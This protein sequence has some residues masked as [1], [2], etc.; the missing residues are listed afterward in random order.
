M[1][2]KYSIKILSKSVIL[3]L[4]S[5]ILLSASA[6]E[7][8]Q[9]DTKKVKTTQETM[10]NIILVTARKKQGAEPVTDTPLSITA[11]DEKLLDAMYVQDLADMSYAAPNVQFDEVGTFPGVQ[12]FTFRGQ[13]INSSIPSVDPTVGMF[14]DG[15]FMGISYGVVNDMFD[16]ESI[17]V[18]RGPQGLLF[19]RNVTGGAVSI[20]TKRP[21]GEFGGKLKIQ[22]TDH[23]ETTIA[24]AI[25]GSLI[26]DKL[27]AKLVFYRNDDK[28]YFDYIGTGHQPTINS[29]PA[30]IA[31][32]IPATYFT[33]TNKTEGAYETTFVRAS[34][35][36]NATDDLEFTLIAED[37]SNDGDGAAWQPTG[38][39]FNARNGEY[40]DNPTGEYQTTADAPGFSKGEWSHLIFETN[41]KTNSGVLTNLT[42]WRDQEFS[43]DAD[44]DGSFLTIF[45]AHGTTQ[46]DQV[47]NELRWAGSLLDDK[48]DL[49]IGHYYFQQDYSYREGRL[50]HGGLLRAALG[51]DMDHDATGVFVNTDY[52][53][54]DKLSITAGLRYTKETKVARV[55]DATNG[56]CMDPFTFQGCEWIDLERDWSNVTPKLG[57]DYRYNESTLVYA[58]WTKGFRSGGVNFR[59][60]KPTVFAPGPLDAEEQDTYE[61]GV[62]TQSADGKFRVNLAYFISDMTNVQREINL[63]DAN[64]AVL[65]ATL[66]AGNA[67]IKGLELDFTAFIGDSFTLL[68]SVGFLDGEYT[69]LI[70][71]TAA[72][73]GKDFPRLSKLTYSLA[74]NYDVDL[75]ENGLLTF[76]LG[77]SYR[78]RAAYTDLNSSYFPEA[79]E[80]SASVN[81]TDFDDQWN[82]SLFGKNLNDEARWGNITGSGDWGPMLKGKRI[83]VEVQYN[84]Y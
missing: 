34:L 29:H 6:A 70:P 21:T 10:E 66:T 58:F 72:Q 39:V 22:A 80:L 53:L 55:I 75:A 2:H 76:R 43:S 24:G 27:A 69:Y 5:G 64:L 47:S 56:Q 41:Y 31:N 48:L 79:N 20:R 14:I 71:A 68:G 35:V 60:G 61:L 83:G 38:T 74:G 62:K 46:Q 28:G 30:G 12:N 45:S 84:F 16:L 8:N 26:E 33:D 37:G 49:T 15:M 81:W 67:Q 13:G 65:Q 9:N 1:K 11:Y 17:E 73:F 32:A 51:G 3:A 52:H 36:F 54:S 82:V 40:H 23:S 25:E 78:D 57:F 7:T 19:G 44:I 59:N 50:V 18:L 63:P 42:T 4:S 77:Y